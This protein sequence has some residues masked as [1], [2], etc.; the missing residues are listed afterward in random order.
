M[1]EFDA[2]ASAA[3][4]PLPEAGFRPAWWLRNPHV[5]SVLPSLKALRGPLVARRAARVLETSTQEIIDCGDGVRLLGH[6]STQV[7]AGREPARDLVVLLHG[8]EG[9]AD[10]L[11]VLSLAAELFDR[12]ADVFR[13]NLRDHGDSHH[14][15]KE[16]FHS[17]RI[18][19]VVGAVARIAEL[20]PDQRLAMGGFSLGGNFSL[21]VAARAPAAG[22][23]LKRVVAVCPVLD[24]RRTLDALESGWWVYRDYFVLK[25][26]RSLRLK[27]SCF[28]AD[29]DFAEILAMR[30]LRAMT[31][32]LVRRHSE[33]P[34][35]ETY[36]RGYAI[37]GDALGALEL[38]SYILTSLDDPIIPSGDLEQLAR[39]PYLDIVTTPA[40]GHCGFVER[41]GG[42]S[43][44]DRKAAELLLRAT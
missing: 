12:G 5:Q 1:T 19:E 37:V 17:C 34:D 11:Y 15:N 25:W 23:P 8:W 29:Y 20:S 13:L 43:W 22:I 28:P 40:G 21:R 39:S 26:K 10:S 9:S 2:A 32:Y 14:L 6:R 18:A 36:L 35:L 3:L 33:F 30:S 38:P 31:D 42:S 24:P 41:L 4:T 27:Q 16:L 7:A 44:I